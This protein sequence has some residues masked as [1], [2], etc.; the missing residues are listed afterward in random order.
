MPSVTKDGVHNSN[1]TSLAY[2]TGTL[3]F[4]TYICGATFQIVGFS[5]E[6]IDSNKLGENNT[7]VFL[8]FRKSPFCFEVTS[9]LKK[10]FF[11]DLISPTNFS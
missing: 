7:I 8:V 3:R 11:K 9:D 4:Q 10:K 1:V 6:L 5:M 2:F